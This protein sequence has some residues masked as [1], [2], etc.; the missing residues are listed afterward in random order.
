MPYCKNCGTQISD[1]A[2]FC[3]KCGTQRSAFTP[4]V[5]PTPQPIVPEPSRQIFSGENEKVLFYKKYSNRAFTKQLLSITCAILS[6]FI[7]CSLLNS[8]ISDLEDECEVYSR[9]S[10]EYEAIQ[11]SISEYEGMKSFF[12]FIAIISSALELIKCFQITKNY[13]CITDKR[14]YGDACPR[15]GFGLVS[16]NLEFR[17]IHS[18]TTIKGKALKGAALVITTIGSRTKYY[19]FIDNPRAAR[20]IINDK[21]FGK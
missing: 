12:I 9:Y 16:F 10:E 1:D 3:T 7:V 4:A 14:V 17:L 18:A 8:F 15:F 6:C 13:I 21:L 5:Q 11:D 19:C 20:R 2:K